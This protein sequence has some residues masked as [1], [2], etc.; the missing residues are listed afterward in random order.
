MRSTAIDIDKNYLANPGLF[1]R[2][3]FRFQRA[4]YQAGVLTARRSSQAF[5]LGF[6]PDF[7]FCLDIGHLGYEARSRLKAE[8]MKEEGIAIIFDDRADYFPPEI[9]ALDIV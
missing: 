3:A 7:V 8:K 6:R 2:I 5:D 9:V 1:D 4:G